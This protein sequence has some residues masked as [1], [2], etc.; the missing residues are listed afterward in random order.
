M[1]AKYF[2]TKLK[3]MLIKIKQNLS[4]ITIFMT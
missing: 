1:E 3:N 4:K 2:I